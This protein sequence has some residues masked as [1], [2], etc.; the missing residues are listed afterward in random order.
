[1][2]WIEVTVKTTSA[3]IELVAERL[4]VLALTAL[5]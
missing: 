1:M 2:Q 5:L 4:T 3:A